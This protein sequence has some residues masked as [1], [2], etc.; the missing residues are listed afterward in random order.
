[1]EA[2]RARM[3]E[4]MA[5]E[6]SLWDQE[7]AGMKAH[8]E[9]LESQIAAHTSRIQEL[10][11]TWP[12]HAQ[13]NL[14]SPS[15]RPD[16]SAS[17][18]L[19]LRLPNG[20]ASKSVPQESGR[21]PDGSAFYAPSTRHPSRTFEPTQ[22]SNLAIDK[23][24]IPGETPLR[25]P[26]KELKQSDFGMPSPP[27]DGP[28]R[29]ESVCESIDIS[30]L[31]PK[32]EGVPIK[33]SAVA[34]DFVAKVLSPSMS[35]S[36]TNVSSP[37]KKNDITQNLGNTPRQ[38][39]K[40]KPSTLE[41]I[42]APENRRLTMNA[43]HTPNHSVHQIEHDGSGNITPSQPQPTEVPERAEQSEQDDNELDQDPELKGPLGLQND[44]PAD[45]L[46]LSELTDKLQQVKESGL[47]SPSQVSVSTV[48]DENSKEAAA[49][50]DCFIDNVL[51]NVLGRKPESQIPEEVDEDE[52][53]S[54]TPVPVLRVK[55]SMNFGRPFGTL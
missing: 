50:A 18:S 10:E 9:R 22:N 47:L 33:T 17:S 32:L 30:I 40:H 1:M 14:R 44:A 4:M 23:I 5:E 16:V 25:M 28:S 6:R 36:P 12:G 35:L 34:P 11:S 48:S 37:P 49:D 13:R 53:E 43:G 8:I 7:R 55:P 42:A 45:A 41:I 29:D 52:E 2:D 15:P 26:A 19:R 20:S 39:L 54:A 31:N 46:F 51:R 21:N 3:L 38:V 27:S 24:F